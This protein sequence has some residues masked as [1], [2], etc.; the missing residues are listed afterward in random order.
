MDKKYYMKLNGKRIE[1]SKELYINFWR[2]RNREKYLKRLDKQ[3]NLTFFS[4]M[5]REW[6]FG[7]NIS[8]QNFYVEKII[9]TKA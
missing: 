8:D 9:E 5:D 1:V 4:S 3:H 7:E 2:E 6:S